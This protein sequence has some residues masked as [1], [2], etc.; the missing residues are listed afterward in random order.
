[1]VTLEP[2]LY[3]DGSGG[4]RF[5]HNYLITES[6]CERLSR[7]SLGL[8]PVLTDL[9]SPDEMLPA[10]N[11]ACQT[12][13]GNPNPDT[14]CHRNW[15]RCDEHEAGSRFISVGQHQFIGE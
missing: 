5:E 3:I 13:K 6:G 15:S 11:F 7:H 9:S 2:G 10:E 1:M 12:L 4:M 14:L 8:R